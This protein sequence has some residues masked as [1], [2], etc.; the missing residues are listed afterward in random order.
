MKDLNKE[1][2]DVGSTIDIGVLSFTLLAFL[3]TYFAITHLF[4]IIQSLIKVQFFLLS[5]FVFGQLLE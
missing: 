2:L 4:K 3:M 5:P 1:T